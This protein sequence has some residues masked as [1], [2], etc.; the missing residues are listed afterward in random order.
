MT[1]TDVEE[2]GFFEVLARRTRSV[3]TRFSQTRL[4]RVSAFHFVDF[5]I[6]LEQNSRPELS[7]TLF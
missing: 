2:I 5:G 7:H 6:I 4:A 1:V 3:H